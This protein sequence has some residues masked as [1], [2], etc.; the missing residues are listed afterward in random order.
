M[1]TTR[2]LETASR[3]WADGKTTKAIAAALGMP[4]TTLSS[5]MSKHRDMFPR[6]R[7]GLAVWASR[8]W[9]TRDMTAEEAARA[10][11]CSAQTVEEWRAKVGGGL[12]YR[13]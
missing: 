1:I 6:R 8:V 7:A 12:W 10:L 4:P 2:Q 5:C 13:R 9:D 3:M 11:G